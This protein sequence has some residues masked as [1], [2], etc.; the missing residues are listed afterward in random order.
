MRSKPA[1]RNPLSAF[2]WGSLRTKIIVWSFVPTA[3][4]L[5]AVALVTFIAYQRV[6][7]E[8]VIERNQEVTHLSAGKLATEITEYT[9]SLAGV[10]RTAEI[11]ENV[12]A[13]QRAA[14]G[15]SEQPSHRI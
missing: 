14:L 13:I 7:E 15:E 2:R 8:L 10:A 1:I 3:I 6:T 9:D 4:V 12:P 11:H 5:T